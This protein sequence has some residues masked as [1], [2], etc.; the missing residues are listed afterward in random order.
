MN[1]T[2]ENIDEL[3]VVLTL[4]LGKED[5]EERV[6]A[7][8][9]D[10]R[11]KA[12]I[13]GFRP[14][15]VPPGMI[16]KMYGKPVLLDEI[17]KLVSESLSKYLVDEKLNI[18]GE[19][20]PHQ[21]DSKKIDL[22]TDS[23][24]EFK[25]DLGMAPELD[26]P[27][28]NKDKVTFYTI[29]VDNELIDKYI[30]SYTQRFGEYMHVEEIQDKDMLTV[31]IAQLNDAGEILEG[32]IKNEEAR[33]ATDVIKDKKIKDTVLKAKKGD[34]LSIDLR[35]AY[36]NDT[37]IASILKI[38]QKEAEAINGMFTIT[39]NEVQR[40]NKAEVDQQL[41]DKVYGE[42]TVKSAEEFRSKI[43]E[44][45]SVGLQRDSEYK[46]KLDAKE[47]MIK[48]F[49]N[50]LPV[51]FLKR[52]LHEINE[53]KFSKEEI[54]KDFDKFLDDLK[55]Q[56]IKDKIAKDNSIQVTE[57]DIMAAARD[58]AR[59][60]FSYYGMNNVPDEHLE[61]FVQRTLENKDQTRKLADGKL[62]DNIIAYIR[63]NVKVEEKEISSEKFNKLFE[64]KN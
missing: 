14:G 56:L 63:Q 64:E 47:A 25:F 4:K 61:T 51:E 31:S 12:N 3:N 16:N 32:G 57:E 19:P 7:I 37:E 53:G 41:F 58:N 45:A 10:Y 22:D 17:N 62:E 28:S 44:E 6:A 40:F 24:F 21:D 42:G 2:R 13:P 36:P 60:Q 1:I 35:K 59:M 54:E 27:I 34:I 48:K 52:W 38:K 15:K 30:D 18:L 8:L 49:K 46:F 11:K 55:W 50:Q 29:K 23:E 20:M 9:K 43:A 5:Y 33:I 39:I 26:F